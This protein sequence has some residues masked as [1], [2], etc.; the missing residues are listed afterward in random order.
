MLLERY[1]KE[2][3]IARE[4]ADH[5]DVFVSFGLKKDKEGKIIGKVS[6]YCSESEFRKIFVEFSK[7]IAFKR[8]DNQLDFYK[9][10]KT[11]ERILNE[12]YK[13]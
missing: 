8:D 13:I 4:I 11:I 6:R 9:M 7:A 5:Y 12:N 2:R 3:R 10:K 1:R